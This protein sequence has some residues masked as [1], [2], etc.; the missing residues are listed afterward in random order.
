MTDNSPLSP[1]RLY[2]VEVEFAGYV[3]AASEREAYRYAN[4]IAGDLCMTDCAYVTEQRPGVPLEEGW[5]ANSI[6]YGDRK[7]Q[8]TIREAFDR[9]AALTKAEA[10][11]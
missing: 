2:R 11:T 6:A 10:K 7:D 8:V 9:M 1:K 4:D 5:D 3:W